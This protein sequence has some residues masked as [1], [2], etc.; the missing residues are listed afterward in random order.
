MCVRGSCVW[1]PLAD[2][3]V[4][5]HRRYGGLV[6][7]LESRKKDVLLC[8]GLFNS[9]TISLLGEPIVVPEEH[10]IT[11]ALSSENLLLNTYR[12]EDFG[13]PSYVC[14][15]TT[16]R[17]VVEGHCCMAVGTMSATQHFHIIGYGICSHE[18]VRA[19]EHVLCAIRDAVN[20]VVAERQAKGERI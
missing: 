18:D 11:V 8:D 10:R 16:H 1:L 3:C 4:P 20:S 15:D 14:V 17:L 2:V 9:H 12:Q 7:Y 13:L 19:H 6:A 5:P